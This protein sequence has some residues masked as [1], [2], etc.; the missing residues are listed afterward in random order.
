MMSGGQFDFVIKFS[1]R[2]V[3]KISG[4]VILKYPFFLP[5]GVLR[6]DTITTSEA[7]F[8]KGSEIGLGA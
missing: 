8:W 1:R 4:A 2:C 6:A 7:L 5:M 3:N